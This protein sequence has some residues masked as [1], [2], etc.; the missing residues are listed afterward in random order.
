MDF[1][2]VLEK[3]NNAKVK[4]N[5]VMRAISRINDLKPCLAYALAEIAAEEKAE[6]IPPTPENQQTINEIVTGGSEDVD[7]LELKAVTEEVETETT[8]PELIE[9]T[10][11]LEE[12]Q[13][14][15]PGPEATKAVEEGE[16]DSSKE[17][18]EA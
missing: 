12:G 11:T 13:G 7:P 9:A 17:Q 3:L 2:E 4:S 8:S 10:E 5:N 14:N 6:A 15:G 18:P 1:T 16:E